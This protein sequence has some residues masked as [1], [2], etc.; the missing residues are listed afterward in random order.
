MESLKHLVKYYE[1]NSYPVNAN[2]AKRIL[3]QK[4]EQEREE[5]HNRRMWQDPEY[6]ENYKIKEAENEI[7]KLEKE[8]EEQKKIDPFAGQTLNELVINRKKAFEYSK[9]LG[10]EGAKAY[11]KEL[12]LPGNERFF[13]AKVGASEAVRIFDKIIPLQNK[14]EQAKAKIQEIEN[15]RTERILKQKEEQE[16]EKSK[17]FKEQQKEEQFQKIEFPF[18]ETLKE[19]YIVQKVSDEEVIEGSPV[20]VEPPTKE[21]DPSWWKMAKRAFNGDGSQ[22]VLD[23]QKKNRDKMRYIAAVFDGINEGTELFDEPLQ[24]Y[25][26]EVL[27]MI[28]EGE[29]NIEDAL[30]SGELCETQQLIHRIK[31]IAY[32]TTEKIADNVLPESMSDVGVMVGTLGVGTGVTKVVAK[33]AKKMLFSYKLYRKAEAQA[34]ALTKNGPTDRIQHEA[35]KT[36]YRQNMEKSVVEDKKLFKVVDEL[37]RENA[38]V[39]SGSTADA[40][41]YTAHT[42]KLVKGSDHVKKTQDTIKFLENWLEN[43]PT[44]SSNDRSIAENILLDMKDAIGEKPW[45]S[46]TKPPKY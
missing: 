4:E 16:H 5:E 9:N 2:I 45:Y 33:E 41:R 21:E 39:G 31:K 44:A 32:E 8:I 12:Q 35:I 34:K 1:E 14:I 23:W 40:Y 28:K 29:K 17:Q 22:E 10:Y 27:G 43:N 30:E 26:T 7:C 24:K 42:G 46:Q 3:K 37:Y 20:L 11:L 6:A 13:D 15:V 19:T 36:Q 18:E 38:E 25:K